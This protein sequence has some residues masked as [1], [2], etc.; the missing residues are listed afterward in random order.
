[1]TDVGTTK[2]KPMPP[3]RRLRIFEAHGG[4]CCLCGEQIDG[5]REPWTIEHLIC[6]G[7]GGIDEDKNCGPAHE[8]CRRDK[9]KLDV[10]AIAK[11]KRVKQRHLGIKA[12]KQPIRGAGFPK[13]E[14]QPKKL[15]KQL[16]PRRG[17]YQEDLNG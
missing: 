6:L 15:T 10:R 12:P 8:T 1:M 11:A 2:R 3:A 13:H 14:K 9:D 16:P 4:K 5:A 17:L 7:L